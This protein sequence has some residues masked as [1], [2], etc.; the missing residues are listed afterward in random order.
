MSDT[1]YTG[2]DAATILS[3]Q[4]LGFVEL[5]LF[6]PIFLHCIFIFHTKSCLFVILLCLTALD[7]VLLHF[8]FLF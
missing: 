8:T 5:F 4:I 7:W 3:P 2:Q 6:D 1:R